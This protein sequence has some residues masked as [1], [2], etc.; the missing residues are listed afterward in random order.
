[1]AKSDDDP[2]RYTLECIE[3]DADKE[4]W[5]KNAAQV[6]FALAGWLIVV[7]AIVVAVVEPWGIT[8]DKMMNAVSGTYMLA[9]LLGGIMAAVVLVGTFIFFI[10]RSVFFDKPGAKR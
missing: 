6:A 3:F 8:F 5:W 9:Y 4:P 1:M 10:V 2:G 7:A